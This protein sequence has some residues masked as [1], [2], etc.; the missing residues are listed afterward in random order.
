MSWPFKPLFPTRSRSSQTGPCFCCEVPHFLPLSGG[1]PPEAEQ[2]GL[3]EKVL[4]GL[5]SHCSLPIA[6]TLFILEVVVCGDVNSTFKRNT[7]RIGEGLYLLISFPF[8]SHWLPGPKPN[9][10]AAFMSGQETHSVFPPSL[11]NNEA[12]TVCGAVCIGE[13]SRGSPA[14]AAARRE[15]E[16]RAKGNDSGCDIVVILLSQAVDLLLLPPGPPFPPFPP[17]LLLS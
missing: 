17:D 14:Q 13:W 9:P 4:T 10:V 15:C 2:A 8:D 6:C 1:G 12:M 5:R 3:W 11:F 7:Q 16:V